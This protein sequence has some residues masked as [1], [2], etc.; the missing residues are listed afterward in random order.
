MRSVNVHA[1]TSSVG[2]EYGRI[3]ESTSSRRELNW[4]KSIADTLSNSNMGRHTTC[5]ATNP[6]IK[7]DAL[8]TED[9]TMSNALSTGEGE[10][11]S[12]LVSYLI[13]SLLS[14]D[15]SILNLSWERGL[16]SSYGEES[17][18]CRS[19]KGLNRRATLGVLLTSSYPI[20]CRSSPM[21]TRATRRSIPWPRR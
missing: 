15:A 1:S 13:F 14:S 20:E 5:A 7:N 12:F 10:G 16:A 21:D 17:M 19:S 6:M 8:I 3:L 4:K 2:G 9:D 18:P 11:E